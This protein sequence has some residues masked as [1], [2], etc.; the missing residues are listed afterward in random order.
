MKALVT[1]GAGFI[2][3]YIVE[4]LLKENYDVVIVDNLS[5]GDKSKVSENVSFY[6]INIESPQLE[7]VFKKENP[8]IVIHA[9]AQINV[10]TSLQYPVRD[11]EINILGTINVLKNCQK[12]NVKKV[13][14]SS[15]CAVYG[16]V[17]DISIKETYPIA[18]FSF[19]GISKYVS[20]LYI[21]L[22]FS[23]YGLNY[24][25]LRYANVYGPRQSTTGEGGVV[26]IFFSKFMKNEPPIIY[27][28][29]NQTRDFIFVEDVASANIKAITLGDQET[30]NISCNDK[31]S[32]SNLYEHISLFFTRHPLPQYQPPRKG[33]ILFSRL[34]NSKAKN[35]LNW[36]PKKTLI[37]GL[38]ITNQY[39]QQ[40]L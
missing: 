9:A 17:E 28:L 6:L 31:T 12:Y 3:S 33:D 18:P 27:G 35:L 19:Y 4:Q 39:H 32:I 25:I 8:D 5:T 7:N 34:D 24:T 22:F 13:I 15:S 36:Y 16:D 10:T 11:G 26:S 37:E 1:G 30:L 2:G 29:G 38:I 23:L 21:R 20:E 40:H 14:Y